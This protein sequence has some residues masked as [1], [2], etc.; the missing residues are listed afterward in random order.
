LIELTVNG[1]ARTLDRPLSLLEYLESQGINPQIIA[2]EHN[3]EII[4]RER[5]P[6]T[7]LES[8]DALEIV[9]MVG[10]GADRFEGRLG[11]L[12]ETPWTNVS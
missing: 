8:G 1:K 9:R 12:G 7:R 2:V 3:G 6:D 4:K 10:G 11:G 5:Y